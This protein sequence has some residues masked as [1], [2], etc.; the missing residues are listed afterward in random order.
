M[1]VRQSLLGI[2]VLGLLAFAIRGLWPATPSTLPRIDV[3]T[4]GKPVAALF[5]RPEAGKGKRW[6]K[7]EYRDVDSMLRLGKVALR[8]F[9]AWHHGRD[10]PSLRINPK[11]PGYDGGNFVELSRPEDP[12]AICN[13][14]PDQLGASL[15]LMHEHSEAVQLRLNGRDLGVYLRSVRPGDDLAAAAGRSPG[16]FFKGDSLGRRKHLDLWA[17]SASWRSIGKRDAVAT[18]ALDG[19]LAALREP[20]TAESFRHLSAVL[21]VGLTARAFAVASLVGSIHAD[22][23]HNHV[24]FYDYDKR[25]IEPLLWD[26]NGFG[27]HADP[28]LAVDVAR[29]PL[30][31]RLLCFPEFVHQRNEALWLL[32][33][34]QGSTHR[35]IAAVDQRLARLDPALQSDPEIGRLVLRR[36]VF[37]LETLDYG[38]LPSARADFVSFVARR[39][40]YLNA[41]FRDARVSWSPS[42]DDP[43]HTIVTVSGTVAVRLSCQS[44]V[45][46]RS[47]F[48]H[49]AS[50]LWPGI[51]QRL[52]DVRQH[53]DAE[54]RGVCA[55]HGIP[56]PMRYVVA[57]R[58]EQLVAHNAI[59]GDVVAA[60][61]R[62]DT[63]EPTRSVHPWQI[64]GSVSATPR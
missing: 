41:W 32:L 1:N 22:L 19:M 51:S 55:P 14:L 31:A 36:G 18:A 2:V 21:D 4:F 6:V 35:L 39:A 5:E 28:E 59:T 63:D 38:E 47:Q 25:R 13:W 27:V 16:T 49:D 29:H 60:A 44:G 8:G 12:L 20:P 24:L 23:V 64:D 45:V 54:G 15:G 46:V 42:P 56:A 43:E 11:G 34:G 26:A 9:S 57:C 52:I 53:Q 33:R 37:E 7:V 3:Q 17:G 62:S 50:L 30:A 10:K 58:A 61:K 40:A 48:G